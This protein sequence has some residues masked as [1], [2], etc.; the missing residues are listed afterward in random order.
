MHSIASLVNQFN[1][2]LMIDWR[3]RPFKLII[4]MN[5]SNHQ[6]LPLPTVNFSFIFKVSL[7]FFFNESSLRG[8]ILPHSESINF[9]INH[10]IEYE[11]YKK[12]MYQPKNT[13]RKI[14]NYHYQQTRRKYW[15][16]L[17]SNNDCSVHICLN[18]PKRPLTLQ[19][20]LRHS[21]LKAYVL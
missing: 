19:T 9:W 6:D 8:H 20:A 17:R 5:D 11:K 16:I 2:R 12:P 7:H 10:C 13:H 1:E 15:D 14:S 21:Y 3:N 18:E 4:W